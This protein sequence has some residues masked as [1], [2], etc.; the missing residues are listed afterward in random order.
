[1]PSIAFLGNS[2]SAPMIA[3]DLGFGLRPMAMSMKP[4]ENAILGSAPVGSIE[5]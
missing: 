1:M 2:A 3:R 4:F 5:K